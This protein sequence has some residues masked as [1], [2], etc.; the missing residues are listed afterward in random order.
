MV[1]RVSV[2]VGGHNGVADPRQG[3]QAAPVLPLVLIDDQGV[4]MALDGDSSPQLTRHQPRAL[5]RTCSCK[6]RKKCQRR[7]RVE[8]R[9]CLGGLPAPNSTRIRSENASVKVKLRKINVEMS[10]LS[11]WVRSSPWARK[12]AVSRDGNAVENLPTISLTLI[13]CQL[14][15]YRSMQSLGSFH[16]ALLQRLKRLPSQRL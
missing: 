2:V 3:V 14:F 16:H 10:A 6:Q 1:A 7:G 12:G 4:I 15:S 9:H 11:R 8:Y 5:Q 13:T